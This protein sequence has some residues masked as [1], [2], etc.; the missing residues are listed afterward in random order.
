[1]ASE[2]MPGL[3][4]KCCFGCCLA[5]ITRERKGSGPADVTLMAAACPESGDKSGKGK[6]DRTESLEPDEENINGTG[7]FR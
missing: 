6:L 3:T 4:A 2:R 1:M 7:P 5:P